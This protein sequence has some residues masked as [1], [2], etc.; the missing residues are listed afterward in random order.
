MSDTTFD[1]SDPT[2]CDEHHLLIDTPGWVIARLGSRTVYAG[3]DVIEHEHDSE[4]EAVAEVQTILD[5]HR[6]AEIEVHLDE[7]GETLAAALDAWRG[8]DCTALEL[9][10]TLT[11]ALGIRL[12]IYAHDPAGYDPDLETD[13]AVCDALLE[14]LDEAYERASEGW[15]AASIGRAMTRAERI[16]DLLA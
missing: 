16:R 12:G 15:R 11:R 2:A 7:I 1:Y 8:F 4:E 9:A 5:E 13:L 3:G 10:W 6:D 14:R